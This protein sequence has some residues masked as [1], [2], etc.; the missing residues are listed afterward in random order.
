MELFGNKAIGGKVEGQYALSDVELMKS[1]L[2]ASKEK[3]SIIAQLNDIKTE[4]DKLGSEAD[5]IQACR[6]AKIILS[7]TK[8]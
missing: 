3:S 7:E 2:A 8:K 6:D 4:C 5:T 1:Q